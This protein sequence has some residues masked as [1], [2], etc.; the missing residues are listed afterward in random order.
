MN[1]PLGLI[2]IERRD[3][4]QQLLDLNRSVAAH[5]DLGNPVTSPGVPADYPD[6]AKLVS[7][8]CIRP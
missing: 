5:I 7:D 2:D 1:V 8:E 6:P 4:L 3:L